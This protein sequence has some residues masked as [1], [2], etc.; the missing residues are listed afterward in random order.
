M[1]SRT[2]SGILIDNVASL[3]DSKVE[4]RDTMPNEKRVREIVED[5]IGAN[6]T[7]SIQVVLAEVE[8]TI[9]NEDD[10]EKA[11]LKSPLFIGSIK[12]SPTLKGYEVGS[13]ASGWIFPLDPNIRAY[14]IKGELVPIVTFGGQT[15]YINGPV[16]TKA[17]PNNNLM[18]LITNEDGKGKS[19]K[20]NVLGWLSGGREKGGFVPTDIP[21]PVK[22]FP[23]DWAINGRNDQ[24]IRIGK[25]G[26][27][28]GNSHSVMKFRISPQ[29]TKAAQLLTPRKEEINEDVASIYMSR[30]EEVE[31]N[32]HPKAGK[33]IT[34]KKFIGDQIIIDSTTLVFNSKKGGDINLYSGKNLNVVSMNVQNIVG[35]I[36]NVGSDKKTQPA[37]LGNSLV[38]FLVEVVQ[39][40]NRLGGKL[41]GATGVGNLGVTVPIPG[42]G[43]AG[44]GLQSYAAEVTKERL[45]KRLLSNNVN[46]SQKKRSGL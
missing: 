45:E 9:Y 3:K 40:L 17:N 46:I 41:A 10:L 14:P 15:Y 8:H 13:G 7:I 32:I 18:A 44:S 25:I 33:E 22:Q 28:D 2:V 24:S 38:D 39:E 4:I 37:V 42:L 19:N 6:S 5:M 16:A 20:G 1:N 43:G 34:P 36:V 26:D 30:D 12:A 31:L 29:E 27:K 35:E 11:N 21:R 23:G